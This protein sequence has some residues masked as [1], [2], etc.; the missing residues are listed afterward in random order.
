MNLLVVDDDDAL[1]IVVTDLLLKE[2]Y[3]ITTASGGR[4]AIDLLNKN[5]FD[6]VLLDIIMP[7]VDGFS[8]LKLIKAEHPKVKVIML[9]A[10]SELKMAVESKK[11]GADDFIAK[12]YMREDLLKSVQLALL[13]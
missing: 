7:D 9:T 13:K 1:R 3:K 12:P 4:E 6:L 2:G 5:R 11:L 10:Y 8:V